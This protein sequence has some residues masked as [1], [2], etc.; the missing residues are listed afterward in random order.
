MMGD[1]VRLH[2]AGLAGALFGAV[3]GIACC[4]FFD[5]PGEASTWP[6]A[7]ALLLGQAVGYVVGF[8]YYN[9]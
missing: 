3:I 9:Q 4:A 6:T 8:F 1:F 7:A 5:I 2:G